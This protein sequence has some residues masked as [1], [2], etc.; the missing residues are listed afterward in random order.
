[1]PSPD[2]LFRL[3]PVSTDLT[4]PVTQVQIQKAADDSRA[5][6]QLYKGLQTF[7]NAIGS[8]ADFAKKRRI[9]EVWIR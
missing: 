6:Q 4:S 8:A 1:M 5:T 3:D 2:K 7:G 9:K